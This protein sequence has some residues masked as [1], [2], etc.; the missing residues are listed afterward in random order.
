MHEGLDMTTVIFA[1]LAIFVVWKLK[2]VLG[3]R[4][5]VERRPEPPKPSERSE[6]GNV[7]RLPGAAASPAAAAADDASAKTEKGR[8]GLA[9]LRAADKAFNPER[10]LNGARTAYEMIITAFASGDRKTLANLLSPEV[11][12]S[13][14]TEIARREAAGQ[15]AS[16]RLVSLDDIEFAD[17]AARGGVVQAT[18]RIAAKMVTV[19][20]ES[21]GAIASGDP[22]VVVS[23][24]EFWTF[25]RTV[26]SADPTW[27]LI[28]TETHPG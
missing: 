5:D 4:V 27:R 26:G 9:A 24:D 18:V 2:S 8:A 20:R 21:D 28:A 14:E 16:T 7:V 3:T 12:A 22:D 10:F 17:G 25:S 13:F 15:T 19:V 23:T 11:L 6:A 1:V